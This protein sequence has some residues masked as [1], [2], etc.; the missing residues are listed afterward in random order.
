MNSTGWRGAYCPADGYVNSNLVTINSS[1][2]VYYD[3]ASTQSVSCTWEMTNWDGS[4]YWSPTLSSCS[5]YGGCS[6]DANPGF[7]GIGQ[8]NFTNPIGRSL[9]PLNITAQCLVPYWSTIYGYNM[10]TAQ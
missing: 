6:Y 4:L 2:V 9:Y 1:T 10:T 8:L 3:G 7:T 5:D